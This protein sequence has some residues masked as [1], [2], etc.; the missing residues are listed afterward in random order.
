MFVTPINTGNARRAA[1]IRGY[2]TFVPL[3]KWEQSGWSYEAAGLGTPAR[4]NAHAPVEATVDCPIPD[5]MKF[6]LS[7]TDAG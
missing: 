6:V 2:S 5:I 7:V 4:S 3:A 1:A